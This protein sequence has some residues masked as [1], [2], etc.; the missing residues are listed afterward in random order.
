M[1]NTPTHT[2]QP[3]SERAV[4]PGAKAIGRTNPNAT[5]EVSVKVR[6]MK[7]LSVKGRPATALT[8]EQVGNT[9]GASQTDVDK[10]IETLGKFGL[11]PVNE[12]VATQ[13][14]TV[15]LRG[16]VAEM[17]EAFQVK[18][19]NY[20]HETQSYRGRTGFLSI[21]SGLKDIIVGVF[22][23]DNRRVAEP[24][25]MVHRAARFVS[26]HSAW[27]VPRELAS[28]YNFPDGDGEGQTVGL[29]E[30]GGGY[31]END[32]KKFCDLA[33]VSPV[34]E[35]KAISTDGT[36]TDSKDGAEGEVMLD[37][38]IVAGICPK[39][40]IAVY[41]AEWGDQGWISALDA[42]AS[43][44]EN[45]PGVVSA[46]WGLAEGQIWSRG[47]G[48]TPSAI[49]NVNE[50]LKDLVQSQVTVCVASGDD[51]SSDAFNPVDGLAHVDFPASSPYVLSVGGTTIPT[52][53]VKQPDIAWKE[54]DGLRSDS[55]G[56]TGGGVSTVPFSDAEETPDWQKKVM[57]KSVNPGAIDGRCIPDLAAN[58]DWTASPYLLVVDGKSEPNGGTSAAAPLVA[59]LLT[60]INAKRPANKRVGYVT[61]LL[62]QTI[63]AG[64]KTVGAAGCTDVTDGNNITAHIGGYSTGPG[65]DAVAGWGTPDGIKLAQAIAQ[66]I[67]GR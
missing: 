66:A 22:G 59:G 12:K 37:V 34:P 61:P 39:A 19:F 15:R 63:G 1:K 5:M 24:S 56:S 49:Q 11:K 18:L 44:Q 42:A 67:D 47:Q 3:G 23:L 54:G 53:G 6:R 36:P 28:H 45:D 10:V 46:S 33:K 62:Y 2:V 38:E 30:F 40:K 8:R 41:F 26:H 17:E 50:T 9:Y 65:Y 35:V 21:P 58:A 31:F 25:Q 52:K 55:G 16:T 14:R 48:W 57:I 32:L 60:L 64:N 13:T 27:Y 7:G 4:L 43:D 29:L 51:G 20:A